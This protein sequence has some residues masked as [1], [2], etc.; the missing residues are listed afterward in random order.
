VFGFS[1]LCVVFFCIFLFILYSLKKQNI[2]T[3]FYRKSLTPV[4][5]KRAEH[6]YHFKAKTAWVKK[7]I[8]QLKALMH[9]K[10]CRKITNEFN[11]Q[12]KTSK[13]ISISKIYVANVIRDHQYQI[14]VLQKKLKHQPPKL[15]ARQLIWGVDLTFKE[16]GEKDILPI[17]GVVEHHSRKKLTLAVLKDK[18]TITLLRYLFRAIETYDKPKIIRTD[19]EGVFTSKLFTLSLWLLGIK[20]QTTDIH[21]P[22]QNGRVEQ[23]FGILKQKLNQ[24]SVD[25]TEQFNQDLQ[26]FR[27]WYNKVRTHNNLN[28]NT[29]EEVWLDYDIYKRNSND[30][31]YFNEWDGLLT[32]FY[33]P[34]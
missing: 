6:D 22:W 4:S 1:A 23:F 27:F 10:G 21:C 15:I 31:Y 24:W 11:R 34:P 2:K 33:H 16:S 7:E 25:S 12:F 18:S 19:N 26:V 3:R 17:L 29:P 30:I 5:V 14:Q 32:G 20:H 28:S 9:H 8:I 13:N